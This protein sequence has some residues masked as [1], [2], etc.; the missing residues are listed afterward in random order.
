MSPQRAEQLV[1][2]ESQIEWAEGIRSRVDK[3]FD[4]VA[5]ALQGAAEKQRGQDRL[6]TLAIISILEEK[7]REVFA[8]DQAGYFIRVWQ[9][10]QDQVR[11]LIHQ[12]PRYR[13]IRASRQL[14]GEP[15]SSSLDACHAL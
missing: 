7:R 8:I 9:D 5:S 1:G 10:L 11:Q 12:D 15:A 2:T 3:E 4:R 14:I 6:D 13:A